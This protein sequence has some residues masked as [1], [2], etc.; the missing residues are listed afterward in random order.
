MVNCDDYYKNFNLNAFRL[1][2]HKSLD[3]NRAGIEHLTMPE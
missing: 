3:P 2:L 1:L